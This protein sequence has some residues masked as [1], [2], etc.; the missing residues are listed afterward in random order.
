MVKMDLHIHSR[1]SDGEH[2]V[3]ELVQMAKEA[4]ISV[5]SVTDH[6]TIDGLKEGQQAAKSAGITFIPGIEISIDGWDEMHL[7]GYG[8]DYDNPELCQYLELLCE[9]RRNRGKRILDYLESK[10]VVLEYEQ[11]L[12]K[13]Q[14]VVARPHIA[15][16]M[17]EEG[18]VKDLNEAFTKYLAT[19]E[20]FRIDKRMRP[21]LEQGISLVQQAKGVAV[22]AHAYSLK[23]TTAQLDAILKSAKAS[24][25]Q[26]LECHYARYNHLQRE[27]LVHLAKKH[28]FFVT[29][30]SDFHGKT[31][32]P[33][34]K[35]GQI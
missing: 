24:G 1:A 5:M 10:K 29:T 16:A 31:I 9:E 11:I 32:R 20:F 15:Q 34:V 12:K 23:L 19:D 18:Y 6:D 17:V 13:A 8:I 25:L 27:T 22:L 7:L 2:S 33:E 28:D 26:G 35:L 30:G 3:E 21:T 14:G 4:N